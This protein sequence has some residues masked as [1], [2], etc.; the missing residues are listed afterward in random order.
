[1]NIVFGNLISSRPISVL[2]MMILYPMLLS[3]AML[4]VGAEGAVFADDDGVSDGSSAVDECVADMVTLFFACISRC[5]S[6][7]LPRAKYVLYPAAHH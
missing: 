7:F 5:S 2:R 1:M 6:A 3:G 4:G